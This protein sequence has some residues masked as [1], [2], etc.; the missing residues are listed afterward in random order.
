MKP[1]SE[2]LK[3]REGTL[4]HVRP[5]DSVYSALQLLAQHEV[6]ALVVMDGGRLVG[7]VSERDYTRKL[8][9]SG[10]SAEQARVAELMTREVISVT[11]AQHFRDCVRLMDSHGI[12]HLPVTEA[13]RIVNIVS[14][15]DLFALQRL[16]LRQLSAQIRAAPDVDT[17][18]HLAGE[19]RAFARNLLDQ[20]V[21]ARQTTEHTNHLNDVLTER[22]VLMVA[23]ER[24]M[25]LGQANWLALGAEG[26]GDRSAG[27]F[28]GGAAV[29]LHRLGHVGSPRVVDE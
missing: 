26:S 8:V 11:P 10:R 29:P 25:D 21:Q 2:L 7:I 5:D 18:R 6:G 20:G 16:S 4:W 24:G 12:R 19:I 28:G 17:L 15:R 27:G 23:A 9:P 14:E 1:V 3:K 13:G 22:L